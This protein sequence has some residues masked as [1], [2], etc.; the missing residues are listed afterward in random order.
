MAYRLLKFSFYFSKNIKNKVKL[1]LKM[2][3]GGL[4][5]VTKGEFKIKDY[6]IPDGSIVQV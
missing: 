2:I 6:N 3:A 4:T 1:S 5:R